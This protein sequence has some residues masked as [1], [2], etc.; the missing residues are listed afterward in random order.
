MARYFE[1]LVVD[2]NTFIND[3]AAFLTEN[4]AT[5][6]FHG[7]YN[8]NYRRV[9]FHI[10]GAHFDFYNT[11]ATIVT[12]Y[13]CTGYTPGALPNAQP[14]ISTAQTFTTNAGM[15]EV[16]VSVF[17]ALYICTSVAYPSY[18][19]GGYGTMIDKVGAFTEGFFIHKP[20]TNNFGPLS[21]NSS[22]GS[23]Q[24][25]YNGA[26]TTYNVAAGGLIFD[27]GSG[28]GL[29]RQKMP[30]VFNG[31]IHPFDVGMYIINSSDTSKYHPIGIAPGL[32]KGNG[33]DI[34][35]PGELIANGDDTYIVYPRNDSD[36]GSTSNGD[37]FF[38]LEAMQ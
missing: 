5:I 26:W 11:S 20:I 18:V 9:H 23:A 3:L 22:S 32:F 6:D 19:W 29:A 15:R 21:Y 28:G 10:G 24:L 17:G 1:T 33:G 36:T 16:F 13:G 27:F 37:F 31:L 8:T 35:V 12:V 30:N 2:A 4:G 25:Y 34:Y 7:V 14:G 38:K